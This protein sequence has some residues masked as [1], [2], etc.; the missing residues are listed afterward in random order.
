[1]A[2]LLKPPYI[3]KLDERGD[4][5]VWVVD[6]SYL[7]G[8]IDEEFTNFGQHYRYPY[9]PLKELWIDQEAAHDERQFF[10][11]HLL[12][13]FELMSKGAAYAQ[14]LV[15]ADRSERRERRRAGDVRKL[16]R[17]GR[18]LPAGADMHERLWKNLE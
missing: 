16:T 9:I 13:E 4:L 6:G 5:Q 12:T 3:Q 8:H 2:K 1:M 14:A 11:Q 18:K 15:E 7:R 10:I 17:D